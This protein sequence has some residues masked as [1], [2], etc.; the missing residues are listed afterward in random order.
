M[1]LQIGTVPIA[2]H[3]CTALGAKVAVGELTFVV[4]V[5]ILF[6][7]LYLSTKKKSVTVTFP[8]TL[9]LF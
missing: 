6:A 8:V 1:Y 4:K 9:N 7:F 2:I 3:W 5:L